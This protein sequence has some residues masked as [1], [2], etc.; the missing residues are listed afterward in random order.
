LAYDA[1]TGSLVATDRG[2][3]L[4]IYTVPRPVVSQP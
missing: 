4:T 1:T 3:F 2:G